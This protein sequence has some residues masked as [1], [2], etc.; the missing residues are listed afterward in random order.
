MSYT[1]RCWSADHIVLPALRDT[2]RPRLTG[3]VHGVKLLFGGTAGDEVAEVRVDTL[4]DEASSRAL[5]NLPWPRL[6][7][8]AFVRAY[9]LVMPSVD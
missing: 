2:L 8:P 1:D 3:A 7:K 4:Y 9:L 5:A 6:E